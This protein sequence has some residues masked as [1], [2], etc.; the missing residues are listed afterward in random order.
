MPLLSRW[1][2]RFSLLYLGLGAT[3][4]AL[5]LAN[6]GY[7]F[8]PRLWLLLTAHVETMFFGW[9]TQFAMGVAFWILPRLSGTKPRGRE[10]LIWIAF[11]LLNLG[12]G[13]MVFASWTAATY[14]AT[15][16]KGLELA[17]WLVFLWGM[18]RRIYPFVAARKSR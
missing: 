10:W 13:L 6:K 12:I 14:L 2:V 16:G 15:V 5:L 11:G 7:S 4:G 9:M 3:F 8:E 17:A 18:W 1:M